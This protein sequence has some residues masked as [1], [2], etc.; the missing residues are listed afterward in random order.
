MESA[1]VR[2]P[3]RSRTWGWLDDRLGIGG[4]RYPVPAH[5]NSLAHTLGGI[6]LA[7]F[8]GLVITGIY[9]AQFYDPTTAQA[10]LAVPVGGLDRA[11][12][13][14]QA[15]ALTGVVAAIGIVI[16]GRVV[17][18]LGAWLLWRSRLRPAPS[19]SDG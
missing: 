14:V 13:A 19:T 15:A 6:T 2:P 8:V 16:L 10:Q 11:E 17:V 4:L 7:S 1:T 12:G 3:R 9:L 5:A 18:A